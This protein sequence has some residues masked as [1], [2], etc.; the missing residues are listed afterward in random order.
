[1]VAPE[2]EEPIV[3]EEAACPRG[4]MPQVDREQTN[5]HGIAA[6]VAFRDMIILMIVRPSIRTVELVVKKDISNVFP[7]TRREPKPTG[8]D[9]FHVLLQ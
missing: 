8:T 9:G 2:V 1:V 6:D 3:V 7:V 5:R 4:I